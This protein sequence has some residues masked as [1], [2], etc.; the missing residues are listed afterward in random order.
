M[1]A[2]TI[3]E[4]AKAAPPAYLGA[5]VAGWTINDWAA[6]LAAIYTGLLIADWVWKKVRAWRLS[7]KP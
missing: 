6:A 4:A 7:R 5:Y 3:M 2:E 1:K